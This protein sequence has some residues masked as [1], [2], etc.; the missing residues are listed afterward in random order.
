M[1]QRILLVDDNET[2][3]HWAAG[4]LR[5]AGYE[6]VTRSQPIGATA[7]IVRENPDLVLL[8][9][10]MPGLEGDEVVSALRKSPRGRTTRV[11]LCSS[12]PAHELGAKARACGADGFICKTSDRSE[13]LRQVGQFLQQ[14]TAANG[15]VMVIVDSAFQGSLAEMALSR[16]SGLEMVI[17]DSDMAAT[18]AWD[19][20]GPYALLLVFAYDVPDPSQYQTLVAAHGARVPII[21][22]AGN[23]DEKSAQR[24]RQLGIGELLWDPVT[25]ATLA[26]AIQ[27][28]C[29][30]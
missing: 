4:V 12:L 25:P 13:Y 1:A 8:D 14:P 30:K 21:L 24:A 26:E 17:Y 9:V 11:V 22:V 3:L 2:I 28:T 19:A 10:N 5:K 29:S 16:F 20:G 27:M 18:A 15:K 23:V 6:T 7:A